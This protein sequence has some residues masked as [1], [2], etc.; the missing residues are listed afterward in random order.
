M[1]EI[2]VVR[3]VGRTETG[4]FRLMDGQR[5]SLRLYA[6]YGWTD[7]RIFADVAGRLTATEQVEV[8]A[9]LGLPGES[10]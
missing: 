1:M 2:V 9:A 6:P 8:A 7:G 4:V 3:S 10:A 5:R